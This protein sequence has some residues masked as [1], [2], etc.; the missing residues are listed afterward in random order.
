M[1]LTRSRSR[2]LSL[3]LPTLSRVITSTTRRS[4]CNPCLFQTSISTFNTIQPNKT[5]SHAFYST[6]TNEATPNHTQTHNDALNSS[7]P[8]NHSTE[9]KTFEDPRPKILN[10][11]LPHVH[12]HG[13]TIEALSLGAKDVGLPMIANGLFP[14]GPIHLV[15]HFVDKCNKEMAIELG[16]SKEHLATLRFK[17][18]IGFGVKMRLR[19][20]Q[21]F[22]NHWP[23]AMALLAHPPNIPDSL[24]H[25]YLLV[26]EIWHH[27]GDKATDFSWYTKRATLA[28]IYTSSELFMVSDTSENFQDTM[29]FVDRRLD[30]VIAFSKFRREAEMTVD[31]ILKTAS[32]FIPKK[33]PSSKDSTTP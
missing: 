23:Q 32:S 24:H 8:P 14:N 21:P 6:N 29:G 16:K 33:F 27:S 13:W 12:K 4:L 20:I 10:A 2:L 26:D 3:S 1:F 31:M 25:L 22:I 30:D 9:H 15:H 28:G 19:M 11:S 7:L 18:K 5:I 17:D